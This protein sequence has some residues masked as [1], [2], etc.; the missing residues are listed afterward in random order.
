MPVRYASLILSRGEQF[1]PPPLTPRSHGFV[2]WPAA[3][4]VYTVFYDSTGAEITTIDGDVT[5]SAIT[6]DIDPDEVDRIPA[7][8]GFETFLIDGQG[9][10][11]K[12]RYGQVIRHEAM[13]FNT[14]AQDRRNYALQFAD[15]FYART[16]LVGS[17]WVVIAG[18]P[19]IFDNSDDGDP[20]GVGPHRV[21]GAKA[22]MRYRAE[23][24]TDSFLM[25]VTL[26]NPGAGKTALFGCADATLNSGL[27]VMFES[28]IGNNYIHIGAAS[29]PYTLTD[30][31]AD[32]PHTVES[33]TN[34]KI[35]Y[36]DD[37]KLLTVLNSDLTETLG[38]WEDA[39]GLVP[40]GKG[41]RHFGASW[42]ASLLSSG[43][44]LSSISMQDGLVD[45]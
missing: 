10:P 3:A 20:N 38:Q 29:G 28:G 18:K 33:G 22:A 30:Q 31:V 45:A 19:T 5:T 40:H 14:P 26:L 23:L 41:Y 25:S 42:Q 12:L 44:Q 37:T 4:Q 15:D 2:E 13:F 34:Y 6:F 8:A 36:D 16:G 39:A 35:R 32:I 11:I 17:K 1:M 21:F 7:G 43:V 24:N 9:R 27:F